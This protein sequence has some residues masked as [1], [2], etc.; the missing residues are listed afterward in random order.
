MSDY[1][2]CIFGFMYVC[3]YVLYAWMYFCLL[4]HIHPFS[5]YGCKFVS[6]NSVQFSS[7]QFRFIH[8]LGANRERI[9]KGQS[10]Q[11]DHVCCQHYEISC[12]LSNVVDSSQSD[13][14]DYDPTTGLRVRFFCSQKYGRCF[15]KVSDPE[16]SQ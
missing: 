5:F 6:I 8:R 4:L 7:V 10:A 3:M 13:I 15:R 12:V 16:S 1:C 11:T 2:V 14:D 9:S